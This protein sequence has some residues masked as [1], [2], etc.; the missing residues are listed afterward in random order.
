MAIKRERSNYLIQSV[1]HAL[2]VIETLSD[3]KKEIGITDLAKRLN[4]HKNNVFR[5][6]ATLGLKG[7]VQQNPDTDAYSLGPACLKAGQSYLLNSDLLTRIRPVLHRCNQ[8]CGE[9]VSF[10]KLIGDDLHFPISLISPN[11]VGVAP[12]LAKT[13]PALDCPVGHLIIASTGVEVECTPQ[14][15]KSIDQLKGL[16]HVIDDSHSEYVCYSML[17]R[18]LGQST[19]G[20]VE[21]LAPKYRAKQ[22]EIIAALSTA[23]EEINNLFAADTESLK[24]RIDIEKDDQQA[25]QKDQISSATA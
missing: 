8:K 20:A 7:F 10:V 23:V 21:V 12:R 5:L 11:E 16:E 22:E 18:G 4:L 9:T 14:T 19:L 25:V 1:M 6:L 13:V 2:E 15:Q 24:N 17:A 3:E